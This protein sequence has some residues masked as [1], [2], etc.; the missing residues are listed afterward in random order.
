M[1]HMAVGEI[2]LRFARPGYSGMSGGLVWVAA[3]AISHPR[4]LPLENWTVLIG[5]ALIGLAI[6]FGIGR[7]AWSGSSRRLG[8]GAVALAVAATLALVAPWTGWSNIA[9]AVALGLAVE[10]RHRTVAWTVM[11]GLAAGLAAAVFLTVTVWVTFF[12]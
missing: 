5:F 10:R 3:L 9:A 7:W 4:G 1:T 8:A 12:P 11:S 2:G 6:A